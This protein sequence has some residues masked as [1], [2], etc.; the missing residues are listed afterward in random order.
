MKKQFN[1]LGLLLLSWF[2][3]DAIL[4]ADEPTKLFVEAVADHPNQDGAAFFEKRIRPV[5]VTHCY[6][7]HSADSEEIEG[8]LVLDNR[9]GIRRGGDLGPAVVPGSLKESVLLEAIRHD[10][11]DLKMPPKEKLPKEVIIDFERWVEMGAPDPRDGSAKVVREEIDIEKGKQFWAFQ[12]PK[13]HAAPSVQDTAWPR[14]DIDRFVLA[15]LEQKGLKPVADADPLTLLRRLYFDLIGLPPSPEEVESFELQYGS[16]GSNQQAAIESVVES[17]LNSPQFGERWGRYWLDVAR[18][19]ESAGKA[20]NLPYPHAWRYRDYVIAAF[21][22]DKP[23]DRFLMEQL[24]G[25]LLPSSSEEERAELTI[26]TGYLAIGTKTL[27]TKDP[28]AYELDIAD[29]QI[30]AVTLGMLGL[31]VACARC[32]DHKFDP[33]PTKDYYSLAGIFRSTNTLYGTVKRAGNFRWSDLLPLPTSINLPIVIRATATDPG[34]LSKARNRVKVLESTIATAP[35]KDK[36]RLGN[37]LAIYENFFKTH[38]AEGNPLPFAMGVQEKQ[39]PADSELFVRGE[40]DKPG[41]LVPRGFPQVMIDNGKAPSISAGSGRKELAEWIASPNNPLTARVMVNRIWQHLFGRGLVSSPDNFGAAGMMP[42]HPELLD[43]L[44]LSFTEN[45]WSI[46]HQIRQIVLSRAYQLGSSYDAENFAIDPDNELV[47]RLN[48]RL[49][50]AEAM[51]DSLL[52]VSGQ[53]DLHPPIGSDIG[54]LGDFVPKADTWS[55]DARYRSVYTAV[56]RDVYVA[57]PLSLFD[58]AD[59][60]AVQGERASTVLPS[61]ALYLLNSPFVLEQCD[62][63][64]ERLLE[65][66]VSDSERIQKLFVICFGRPPTSSESILSERHLQGFEGISEGEGPDL[67]K[68]RQAA[69]STLCQ[70][71]LASAEFR[72]LN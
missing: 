6:K 44:A 22:A 60:S 49:L 67:E 41:Q 17:L 15:A 68:A 43:Y 69:W 70:A 61:Q 37:E 63:L 59:A 3:C 32:H 46:K 8:G 39:D 1:H 10:N 26:A 27:N 66:R 33:I 34:E 64:A 12:S 50:D 42:S 14:S 54:K 28:L 65:L 16:A 25:D 47:W 56:Y 13:K 29:E 51:R 57:E 45:G 30:E 9:E 55:P 5:L 58:F 31:T 23:Y 71:L 53:L 72:S 19:G 62:R 24:A 11:D 2:F 18:Y 40:P 52:A 38:D 48:K 35:A 36:F 21:N 4:S 20:I 7:C